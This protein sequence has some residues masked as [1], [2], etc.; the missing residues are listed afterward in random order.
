MGN[1]ILKYTS[2]DYTSIKEDLIDAISTLTNTW[3]SREEGDPGIVLVK[4]MSA[5]GD[6]LSYNQDKQALECFAPTVS[7]RKNAAKLF[8][9]VGY[10]M[11]WYQSAQTTVTLTNRSAMPEYVYYY[12]RIVDGENPV[13]VYYDY[14]Y[15]YNHNANDTGNM[16]ISLP[17]ITNI[18]GTEEPLPQAMVT[19]GVARPS[20]GIQDEGQIDFDNP[21][22]PSIKTNANFISHSNVFANKAQEVYKYWQEDNKVGLYTYLA[23]NTKTLNLYGNDS[24]SLLYTL[25]P[26]TYTPE[27]DVITGKY[28]PNTLLYPYE[29]KQFTAIQGYFASIKFTPSQIKDNCYYVPDASLDDTYIYVSYTTV[30]DNTLTEKTVFIEKTD[31]LLTVT[32]FKD[33][34]DTNKVKVYFQFDVD[35]F[36]YP[37]IKFSSYWKD[38]ISDSV[39]FTLYYV[40]TQGKYGSITTNYLTRFDSNSATE[41]SVTNIANSNY[42]IDEEGNY[43]CKPGYNPQTAAEAYVDSMNYIMT[44]DT[45]VTIYDFARFIRRQKGISNACVCDGQYSDDLNKQIMNICNSY[46]KEQLLDILGP[47]AS[48]S[49]S[50]SALATI[51]YNIRKVT[52]DYKD[53]CYTVDQALNPG[54]PSDF[55]NYS[56]NFYPIWGDF[57]TQD[58]TDAIVARYFSG[59]TAE[60]NA[61][62]M[63]YRVT[64]EDDYPANPDNYKVPTLIN[65]AMRRTKIVTTVPNYTAC[66]VFPWR[67][68]GTIH[69]TQSVNRME[70]NNIIKAVITRLTNLYKP[71]NME[72]GKKLTYMEVI[73][74]VLQSDNR[75]RYFDAGIGNKKLIDFENV[76]NNYSMYF[77]VEA[78]FNPQSIM[79]YVQTYHETVEDTSSPYYNMIC[80]DPNY[81][82]D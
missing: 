56:I 40:K 23:G 47:N 14:R 57:A 17:P 51:L 43:L 10:K 74:A 55:I 50:Q 36:D 66:R 45:L 15:R 32:D 35:E 42:V 4:E 41:V 37:Y 19:A 21:P 67:C 63:L 27:A 1:K 22:D 62:F 70:A 28:L 82:Q 58:E 5:L 13:D 39:T 81:I 75:I 7:Q 38:Q 71:Y 76:L 48:S 26:T 30:D 61:P 65:T 31:N 33:P 16:N 9:L 49:S 68:C 54:T 2:K 77:N 72:F 60:T 29:P 53:A 80:I 44:Y 79:R 69:L 24:Y 20:I 6:M 78:Y 34:T 25:L 18:S 46:T 59:V 52:A 64:T 12:K 73:D 11:H 3:T 8:G